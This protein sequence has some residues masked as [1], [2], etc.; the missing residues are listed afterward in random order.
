MDE[1]ESNGAADDIQYEA[2][3]ETST[4]EPE[5]EEIEENSNSK[6]KTLLYKTSIYGNQKVI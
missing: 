1:K 2:T 5:L 4:D 3:K 6:I